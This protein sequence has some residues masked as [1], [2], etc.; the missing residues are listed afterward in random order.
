MRILLAALVGWVL[1]AAFGGADAL[2]S[3]KAWGD[4]GD[5]ASTIGAS[6][7]VGGATQVLRFGFPGKA[8]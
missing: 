5:I 7:A 1:A 4:F 3:T 8:S 6:F 2:D